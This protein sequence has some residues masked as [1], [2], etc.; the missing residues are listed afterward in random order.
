MYPFAALIPILNGIGI[1]LLALNDFSQG[2]FGWSS[3]HNMC[4]FGRKSQIA[5]AVEE[6]GFR[7]VRNIVRSLT[8]FRICNSCSAKAAIC[9]LIRNSVDI[10]ISGRILTSLLKDGVHTTFWEHAV[11]FLF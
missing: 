6:M 10:Y 8:R 3:R 11:S 7:A 4:I 2:T 5:V 9:L 1:A